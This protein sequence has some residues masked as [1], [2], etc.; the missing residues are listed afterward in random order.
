[1][2]RNRLLATTLLLL[3]LLSLNPS[4]A[5]G[6]SCNEIIGACE[7]TTQAYRMLVQDQDK[8]I[9]NLTKQRD[10]LAQK[11]SNTPWYFFVLVGA[12]GALVIDNI[13]K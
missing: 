10:E 3:L 12:A 6:P 13:R 2:L 9:I 4:F 8:L 7:E 1:M 11:P 5:A